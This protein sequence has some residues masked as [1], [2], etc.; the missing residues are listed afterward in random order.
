M[1][2]T[3]F[4]TLRVNDDAVVSTIYVAVCCANS[5]Q[6][7]QRANAMNQS[8]MLHIKSDFDCYNYNGFIT[9]E[10]SLQKQHRNEIGMW[11]SIIFKTFD[12]SACTHSLCTLYVV[13]IN[14]SMT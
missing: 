14:G 8:Q 1:Q 11:L 7:S 6:H 9:H 5:K 2:E 13:Q 3:F 10:I 4:M 12:F